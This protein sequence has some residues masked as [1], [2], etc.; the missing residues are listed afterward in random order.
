MLGRGAMADPWLFARLRGEA[1]DNPELQ[2]RLQLMRKFLLE[3]VKSYT[4][5]FCGE[6]QV[7]SR[8]KG[9]LT[10]ME[11]PLLQPVIDR[12]KKAKTLDDFRNRL[13]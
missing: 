11:E 5:L 10:A 13:P 1:I 3:V 2:E 6:K 12:L 9:V 7:L 4:T 8:L